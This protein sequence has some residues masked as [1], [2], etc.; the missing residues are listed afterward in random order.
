M[1]KTR[2]EY[3][4]KQIDKKKIII[5]SFNLLFFL[6]FAADTCWGEVKKH[7]RRLEILLMYPRLQL[8]TEY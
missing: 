7:K 1:Q 8:E 2:S 4:Q 3:T 6:K 5:V